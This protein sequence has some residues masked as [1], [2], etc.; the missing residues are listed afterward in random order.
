MYLPATKV[1]VKDSLKKLIGYQGHTK[2]RRR[3][4]H[5]GNGPLPEGPEAFLGIDL[6]RGIHHSIVGSL[7]LSGHNLQPGLD[8]VSRGHQRGCWHTSNGTSNQEG[9]GRVVASL[10]GKSRLEMGVGREVNCGKGDISEKASS[11]TLI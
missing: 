11:G 8:D 1:D 5:S 9:H 3:P 10:V 2:L 4:T 7:T 6:S